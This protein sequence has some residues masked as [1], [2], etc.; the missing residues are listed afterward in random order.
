MNDPLDLDAGVV[1]LLREG[2]DGLQQIFTRL[3]VNIRPSG[4]D[5]DWREHRD[6]QLDQK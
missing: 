6:F 1:E 2:V 5:L 3:R 4:R